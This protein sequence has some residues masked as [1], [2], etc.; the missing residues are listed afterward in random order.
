MKF[1]SQF[2]QNRDLS[3]EGPAREIVGY[4]EHPP[5]VRWPGDAKVAVQIVINYEEGSE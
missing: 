4:G 1:D 3:V 5:L 2:F